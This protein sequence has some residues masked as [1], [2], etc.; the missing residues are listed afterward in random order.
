MKKLPSIFKNNIDKII[1]T[2]REVYHVCECM[3][4]S[5]VI[6][7]LDSIFLG[8]NLP[9]DIPVLIKTR[10]SVYDTKLNFMCDDY[11]NSIDNQKIYIKDIIFIE[12]KD[13]KF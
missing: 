5:D 3:K 1:S 2:N 11:V 9:Q 8:F 12:R 13:T 10:N 6:K 7:V 4:Y